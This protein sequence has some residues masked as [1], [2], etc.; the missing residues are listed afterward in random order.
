MDNTYA[1]IMAGGVGSR[2]WPASRAKRP[3]QL[4]DLT[5][6][7]VPMVVDTVERMLPE[8]P[9]D[10]VLVITGE[11]L[12]EAIAKALP[13]LPRENI[14]AEPEGHNTAP[15]VG[16]AALHV[17]KRD[18]K[19][20]MAVMPSDHLVKNKANFLKKLKLAV[21]AARDGALVTFGVKPRGPETGFGYVEMAEEVK[22]GVRRVVR[23]VEKPDLATAQSY[24]ASWNFTWN[25]GMF[26]FTAERVLEE[27]HQQM[28][29]LGKGLDEIDAALD[30]NE[31]KTVKRVYPTLPSQSIDIGIM[32]NAKN[33]LCVPVHF[34]WFDMGSWD[35][36]YDLNAKDENKNAGHKDVVAHK[37]KGCF[38]QMKDEKKLVAL[39]GVKNLVVVDT[40]DALLICNRKKTQNVKE[41]VKILKEKD[42][43]ELL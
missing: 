36:A 34:G 25:S 27:I 9:Y 5:G 38:I 4:L 22:K 10:R 43:K 3:K 30:K 26:F 42:R 21:S 23:F 18:P 40:G 6:S 17:R 7:G 13:K 28:P 15:C 32:E 29:D 24:V 31:K 33:I 39:A 20:L 11:I 41:I 12:V 16:W 8:I 35:A 14:L 1:V 2:F 37:S 19:G